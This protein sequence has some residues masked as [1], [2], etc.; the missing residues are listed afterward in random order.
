[1]DGLNRREQALWLFQQDSPEYGVFN[2]PFAIENGGRLLWWPLNEALR[3]L[4]RRHP[5]L[6]TMFPSRDGVP[7]RRVLDPDDPAFARSRLEVRSSTAEQIGADLAAFAYRPIDV[8]TELPWRAVQFRLADR[9]VF[10]LVVHHLVYDSHSANTVRRELIELYAALAATRTVPPALAAEV[11]NGRAPAPAAESLE[12]WDRRLDGAGEVDRVLAMGRTGPRAADFPGAQCRHTLSAEAVAAAAGLGKQLSVSRNILMLSLFAVLLAKHGLGPDVVVGVPVST[13]GGRG[14]AAVGFH[15]TFLG[16]RLAVGDDLTFAAFARQ[17]REDFLTDMT[18]ADVSAEDLSAGSFDDDT[19]LGR[20]LFRHMFNFTADGSFDGGPTAPGE[21]TTVLVPVRHARLDLEFGVVEDVVDE[22]VIKA[23]F[24]TD[25]FT[26]AEIGALTA[27]YEELLLA[28]AADPD[29]R[30]AALSWFT[31]ADRAAMA[32]A[33]VKVVDA[34]GQPLPPGL[35]GDVWQDGAATG[36][37]GVLGLD[38]VLTVVAVDPTA[39]RRPATGA[40]PDAGGSPSP[41]AGDPAGATNGAR[42]TPGAGPPV[43][44]ELLDELVGLWR[45]LLSE[46]NADDGTHFFASGG[47][48]LLAARLVTRIKKSRG[49]KV[50]MRTVFRNPTPARLAAVIV[51]LT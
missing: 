42:V 45:T 7:I 50:S 40:R 22:V 44:P 41:D 24:A 6:R 17:A 9:D 10:C 30:L 2:V 11:A 39:A 31:P 47:D 46:P 3:Q 13:R 1:M 43:D 12:Y 25:V 48:S 32:K 20:P 21:F 19:S 51:P 27:R 8:M 23:N 49:I 28:A 36:Q 33:P 29:G 15:V 4:T 5:A 18:H 37:R 26:M 16:V 35:Q 14:H 38:G 34:A